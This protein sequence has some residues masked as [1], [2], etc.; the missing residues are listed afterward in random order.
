VV[1]EHFRKAC[2]TYRSQFKQIMIAYLI[3]FIL[4]SIIGGAMSSAVTSPNLGVRAIET[5]LLIIALVM[6]VVFSG[7]FVKVSADALR[8]K[9][10]WKTIL[11]TVRTSWLSI[12]GATVITSVIA[13]LLLTPAIVLYV[14]AQGAIEMI[15][16]AIIAG[17]IGG[18]IAL[19]MSFGIYPVAI[20]GVRAMEGV[21]RSWR[22]VTK[23]YLEVF[24][25]YVIIGLVALAFI[26][27]LALIGLATSGEPTLNTVLSFL[28]SLLV[29][30]YFVLITTSYY[31]S[32]RGKL[33]H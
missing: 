13:L 1:T 10:R 17:I 12:L 32:R 29:G 19:T 31:L 4:S 24:L 5:V 2:D 33:G 14:I 8:G 30:P 16:V 28:F 7:A 27:A 26:I 11:T 21:R 15:V 23:N 9:A 22:L 3:V 25:L 20:D 6:G 18:L